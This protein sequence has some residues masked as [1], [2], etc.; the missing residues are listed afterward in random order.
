MIQHTQEFRANVSFQTQKHITGHVKAVPR[1]DQNTTGLTPSCMADASMDLQHDLQCNREWCILV[2]EYEHVPL[3]QAM[4]KLNQQQ[5]WKLLHRNGQRGDWH[6]PMP[7]T[8]MPIRV[9][10]SWS[11]RLR[12]LYVCSWS[13]SGEIQLLLRQI[14]LHRHSQRMQKA[15]VRTTTVRHAGHVLE[16]DDENWS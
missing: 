11:P 1:G 4:G 13:T 5:V 2:L 8:T 16:A 7:K 10:T 14:S 12:G 3:L 15:Q 9:A 6:S